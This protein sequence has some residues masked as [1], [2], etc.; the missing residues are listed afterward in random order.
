MENIHFIPQNQKNIGN[1][2]Y[3]SKYNK[4]KFII[5][6]LIVIFVFYCLIAGVIYWYFVLQNIDKLKQSIS[7]IDSTN[8]QYYP[9]GGELEQVLFNITDIVKNAYNPINVIKAVESNYISNSSI[10]SFSY[11]K[12]E[13]FI[14]IAMTVP[15][16][17]DVTL[18]VQKFSS[19]KGVSKVDFSSVNNLGKGQ[20]VSFEVK[21]L[22]N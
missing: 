8:S 9:K 6:N 19:I 5:V 12:S 4:N 13:K 20:E 1:L 16:Y 7:N 18:Q 11:N 10:S 14:N 15:T 2:T 21:V 3:K 22:L 17:N